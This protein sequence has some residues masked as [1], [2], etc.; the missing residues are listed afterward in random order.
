MKREKPKSRLDL[1]RANLQAVEF[2]RVWII[3]RRFSDMAMTSAQGKT[4]AFIDEQ[5]CQ[6]AID[7]YPYSIDRR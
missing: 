1:N 2:G 5:T 3:C 6:K 4:I 7:N